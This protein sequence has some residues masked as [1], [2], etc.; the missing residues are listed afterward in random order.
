[1][2]KGKYAQ[3]PSAPE[4]SVIEYSEG[5]AVAWYPKGERVEVKLPLDD[6]VPLP[7]E[8]L[9]VSWTL[10]LIEDLRGDIGAGT[11]SFWIELLQE[12]ADAV[13]AWTRKAVGDE[14]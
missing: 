9:T 7:W 12:Y 5:R 1:M 6:P 11:K 3:F 13:G 4:G 10:N 14:D 8:I 2:A